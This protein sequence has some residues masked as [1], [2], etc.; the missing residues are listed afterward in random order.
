MSNAKHT[1]R[2]RTQLVDLYALYSDRDVLRA[3]HSVCL[4][5]LAAAVERHDFTSAMAWLFTAHDAFDDYVEKQNELIKAVYG[6]PDA[7]R[8]LWR[9]LRW[10]S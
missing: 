1:K 6:L 8:E 10:L 3:S 2:K 4:C 7:S 9:T 5:M